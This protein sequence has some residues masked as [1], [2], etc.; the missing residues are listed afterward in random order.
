M[1]A[2]F[3]SPLNFALPR[4]IS[5]VF[6]PAPPL[7]LPLP[8]ELLLAVTGMATADPPG[9]ARLPPLPVQPRP[10]LAHLLGCCFVAWSP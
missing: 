1:S 3:H 8:V 9:D 2:S 10:P 7:L 4:T 5:A 6:A